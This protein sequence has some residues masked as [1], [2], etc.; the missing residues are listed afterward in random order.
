M[1]GKQVGIIF[2]TIRWKCCLIIFARFLV[3]LRKFDNAVGR[4]ENKVSFCKF[5]PIIIVRLYMITEC[6][7]HISHTFLI[8]FFN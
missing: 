2:I 3:I 1:K 8:I 5:L 4:I 6:V 7:L